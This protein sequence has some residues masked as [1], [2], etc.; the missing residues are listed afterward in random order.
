MSIMMIVRFA[1]GLDPDEL[2]RRLRERHARYLEVPGLVQKIYGRDPDTGDVCSVYF[3]K[4]R[5]ALDAFR[6]TE[7]AQ[8]FSTAFRAS[9]VRR[10][11]FEV[12]FPL[13][14]DLGPFA[15]Q[16]GQ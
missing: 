4:D 7:L 6:R 5:A 2:D 15:G 14:P 8:S 9:E 10:E 16:T 3:F 13:R 1:S 11:V 12:L